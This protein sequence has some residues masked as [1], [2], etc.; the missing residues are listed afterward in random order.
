MIE[1]IS[2]LRL[3]S[4]TRKVE[5]AKPWSRAREDNVLRLLRTAATMSWRVHFLFVDRGIVGLVR[6]DPARSVYFGSY[7]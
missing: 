6:T 1:L 4:A 3:E 7:E 5:G 2:R